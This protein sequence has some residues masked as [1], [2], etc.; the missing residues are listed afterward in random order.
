MMYRITNKLPSMLNKCENLNFLVK[1]LNYVGEGGRP[2][3]QSQLEMFMLKSKVDTDPF[4][5]NIK[6]YWKFHKMDNSEYIEKI[7]LKFY[8]NAELLELQ[9]W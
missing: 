5:M 3:T 7:E 4:A 8:N 1:S 6:N 2:F 9:D